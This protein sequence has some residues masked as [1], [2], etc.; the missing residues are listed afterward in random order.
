[1]MLKR[2]VL[3]AALITS[4]TVWADAS[5]LRPRVPIAKKPAAKLTVPESA[6]GRIIV[7]FRDDVKA[8]PQPDGV[9][10]S[11]VGVQ[12]DPIDAIIDQFGVEFIPA[13]NTPAGELAQLENRAATVSLC[14]VAKKPI[15]GFG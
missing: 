13:I 9:V 5:E 3:A 6:T 10:R 4:S 15:P 1:M 12:L 7:K 14:G 11:A 2:A 8:R